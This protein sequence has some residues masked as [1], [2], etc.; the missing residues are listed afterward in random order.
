M[1]YLRLER[2]PKQRIYLLHI[3]PCPHRDKAVLY[4]IFNNFMHETKFHGAEFFRFS[5]KYF[6]ILMILSL[7]G[8]FGFSQNLSN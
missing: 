5:N 4:S 7:S 3:I 2:K 1:R 6:N 8:T